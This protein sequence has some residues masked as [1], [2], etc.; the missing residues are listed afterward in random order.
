MRGMRAGYFS[1]E[2]SVWRKRLLDENPSVGKLELKYVNATGYW[3]LSTGTAQKSV[4]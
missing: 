1:M 2:D 3:L 4:V